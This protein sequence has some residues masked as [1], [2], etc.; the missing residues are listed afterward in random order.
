MASW[1]RVSRGT[2]GRQIPVTSS[3][4]RA[5]GSAHPASAAEAQGTDGQGPGY[6][7][8]R[9]EGNP[10]T[11][12]H[13]PRRIT[14]E[15]RD[16]VLPR[17]LPDP[18]EYVHERE[19]LRR[20]AEG[21]D[22]KGGDVAGGRSAVSKLREGLMMYADTW[23]REDSGTAGHAGDLGGEGSGLGTSQP[24]SAEEAS[25]LLEEVQLGSA[26]VQ[27]IVKNKYAVRARA[28]QLAV[29]EFVVGWHETRHRGE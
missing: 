27:D 8:A 19:R 6:P 15:F 23:R 22:A 18:P 3:V 21:E 12:E 1:T 7:A 2:S 25:R 10:R 4:Q 20:H 26:T 24:S 14:D 11:R 5:L 13:A 17:P 28:F 16:I 29:K 9:E